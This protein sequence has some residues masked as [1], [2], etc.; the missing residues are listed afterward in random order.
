[1]RITLP[2]LLKQCR[3]HSCRRLVVAAAADLPVLQAV[4]QAAEEGIVAPILCGEEEKIRQLAEEHGISLAGWEILDVPD[5]LAA[6]RE[7]VGLARTGRADV[8]MK[9][10]VQTA[11]LLRAVLNRESGL[12]S[13]GVL[14]HVAAV[15]C[16]RLGRTLL[17]TDSAICMYPDLKTKVKLVENA[18]IVA[19][20]LGIAM[21]RVAPLAAVE[22]VNPDMQATLDAAALTQMNRRGQLKGCVV[23]GPLAMDVALSSEAAQH[24]KLDSPV[25]GQADILLFHNIEAANSVYKTFTIAAGCPV[26]GVVIGAS[27]PIVLTSRAD[28]AESKLLSIALACAS[29]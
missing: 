7:A 14:S 20:G 16:E 1:M 5:D 9:G 6:V 23:D 10:L 11:D 24:K 4:A 8:V 28:S 19:R 2:A 15:D 3:E 27:A 13:R 21:P 18:A 22:V 12:R 25:A 17:L 26:G 29:V